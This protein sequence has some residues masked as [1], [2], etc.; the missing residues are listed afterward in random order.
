VLRGLYCER[1][2]ASLES[3]SRCTSLQ[4]VGVCGK[5]RFVLRL[6]VNSQAGRRRKRPCLRQAL[7]EVNPSGLE[8][9]LTMSRL[10][11][12]IEKNT[13]RI[14][15]DDIKWV[16]IRGTKQQRSLGAYMR[17]FAVVILR[18]APPLKNFSLVLH[19]PT[20]SLHSLQIYRHPLI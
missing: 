10:N 18:H 17:V 7:S 1:I 9:C 12:R 13:S 14:V 4:V 20:R 3:H 2:F 15:L 19:S 6:A 11:V 8:L 5:R 16:Q